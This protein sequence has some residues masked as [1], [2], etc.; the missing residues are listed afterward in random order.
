MLTPQQKNELATQIEQRNPYTFLAAL[1]ADQGMSLPDGW[2]QAI[3]EDTY[4]GAAVHF[5][6]LEHAVVKAFRVPYT[7]K[8]AHG[9]VVKE[10]LLV[11]FAGSA[12]F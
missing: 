2:Q 9:N 3:E 8:D 4:G 7:Y 12:G 5:K 10:Y 1:P 6:G 11:Y